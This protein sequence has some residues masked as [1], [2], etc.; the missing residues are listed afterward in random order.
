MFFGGFR[1]CEHAHPHQDNIRGIFTVRIP[2]GAY[3][4]VDIHQII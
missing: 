1:V 2:I 4:N 3:V